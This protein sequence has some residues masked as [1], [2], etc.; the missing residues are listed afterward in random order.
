MVLLVLELFL[1]KVYVRAVMKFAKYL[2]ER[3]DGDF[4]TMS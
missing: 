4:S 2:C 1:R 3:N